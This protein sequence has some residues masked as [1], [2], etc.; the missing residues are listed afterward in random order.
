M[1]AVLEELDLQPAATPGRRLAPETGAAEERRILERCA[2]EIA[3]EAGRGA[4][5]VELGGR[6]GGGAVLL[7]AAISALGPVPASSARRR[8]VFLSGRRTSAPSDRQLAATLR[9]VGRLCDGDALLVVG[10]ADAGASALARFARLASAAAWE[11]RQLWSDGAAA[12]AVH[13]LARPAA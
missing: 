2:R 3:L 5:V 7:E 11:Q 10:V 6:T 1:S 8:V 12:F 13:V 9:R 4:R